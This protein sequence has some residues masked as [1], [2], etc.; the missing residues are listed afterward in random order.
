MNVSGQHYQSRHHPY[1]YA[2]GAGHPSAGVPA[3]LVPIDANTTPTLTSGATETA[4]PTPGSS[5]GHLRSS[6]GMEGGGGGLAT[7]GTH[8]AAGRSLPALVGGSTPAGVS[9]GEFARASLAEPAAAHHYHHHHHQPQS[10]PYH[11]GLPLPQTA[12]KYQLPSASPMLQQV[13][14]RSG[15]YHHG[16]HQALPP[17]QTL[18]QQQQAHTGP[19]GYAH[20]VH[21]HPIAPHPSA[22]N[23]GY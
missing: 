7:I 4:T 8:K 15:Y 1:G 22:N 16:H 17:A 2:G 19:L 21:F 10:D 12:Q 5:S 23:S 14:T 18:L 6:H 13:P 3:R 9:G 20:S 11:R